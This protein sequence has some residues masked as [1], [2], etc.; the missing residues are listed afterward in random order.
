MRTQGTVVV[1]SDGS[2]DSMGAL[3]VGRE[4]ASRLGSAI[5]LVSVLEPTGVLIPPLRPEPPPRHHGATRLRDRRE[6]LRMLCERAMH[7]HARVSTRMLIGDVATSIATA[8]SYHRARL[9]VTGRVAHGRIER[10]IRRETPL[11]VAR[12]GPVPVLSVPSATSRLPRVVVVA[13][14]NGHSASRLGPVAPALFHDAVEV[15]LVSVEPLVPT[16]W[17]TEARA[18]EKER[19]H[20][21]QRTFVDVMA[22]WKLPADVP[23]AT[24]ILTGDESSALLSFVT[25]VGA[26]LLVVGAAQRRHGVHLPA[27]DMATKLYRAASCS[28]LLIPV[29]THTIMPR[30]AATSV[31]LDPSEWP[32]LLRDFALR[33]GG[34]RASLTVD[35]KGGPPQSVVQDWTLSGVHCDRDAGTIAIM[36]A[37]PGDP[38]RHV[39]HVVARPT[40]LA[41][42][43]ASSGCDDL[44]VAGYADGQLTLSLS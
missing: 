39:S 18:E 5:E 8:A 7:G 40:V 24:H 1:A 31:S 25:N 9:V 35:E 16:P 27:T 36:L 20:L 4:L 22:S 19:T 28:I 38:Q 29:Q 34:R 32:T 23:I 33:N 6:R 3:I 37:D 42:Q 10:A 26:D 30:S 15:H 44:L 11:A 41:L 13:V 17:E 14:G 21:A 12:S 2:D 43:G